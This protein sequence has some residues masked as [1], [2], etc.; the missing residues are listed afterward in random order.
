MLE[1]VVSGREDLL[2]LCILRGS[3]DEGNLAIPEECH[4]NRKYQRKIPED[5]GKGISVGIIFREGSRTF[6]A[7]CNHCK[8]VISKGEEHFTC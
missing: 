2:R 4:A 3:K 6:E 7:L 1:G 8:N 5:W